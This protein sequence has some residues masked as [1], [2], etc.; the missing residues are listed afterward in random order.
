[1]TKLVD[2]GMLR[3]IGDAEFALEDMRLAHALS[4]SGHSLGKIALYVGWP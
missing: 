3:P 4:E 2:A 1:M